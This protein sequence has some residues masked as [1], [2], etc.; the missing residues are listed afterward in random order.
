MFPMRRA[1][2]PTDT[3]ELALS[4]IGLVLVSEVEPGL[5]LGRIVET[6]AYLSDDEACHAYR[7]RTRR[8]ASLF[9]E[10][11]HAYVYFTYGSSYC[12]NV[13]A[14]IEGQ[15]TG[16]LIRALEP[17]EG[18]EILAARRRLA[19]SLDLCRGP[20]RLAMALGVDL[21]FD[22]LDLCSEGKL[23]LGNL[24]RARGSVGTSL[25]IGLSKGVDRPLRFYERGNPFV[26][27][28]RK[29]RE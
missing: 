5:S 20:G 1:E 14:G 10:R 13:T 7:G 23:W 18:L 22:G 25:R 8:N 24:P 27:G 21:S 15:G 19:R 6:E 3:V 12:L 9:L 2:L 28:T 11:G 29:Q 4:L 26:S 16:V 17:L